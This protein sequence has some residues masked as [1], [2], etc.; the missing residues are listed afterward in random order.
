MARPLRYEAAGAVYHVMARGDG[1]KNVFE[2]DRDRVAWFS[3]M[4]RAG[5]RFGWRVHAWVLMGN[6]FHVLLETPEPNLVVGMKWLLGV[7]SQ[8]W[9]RR[10]ERRGHVFQGRYKA[11]IVNGEE[12]DGCYFRIVADYIHL[13]PVRAGWVGGATGKRLRGWRWSS[14]GAYAGGRIPAWM[15]TGKVLAAFRLSQDSAG[16]KAYAGYLEARAKDRKGTLTD[17]SS[18]CLRRGW[19]L[20]EKGFAEKVL[21]ALAASTRPKRKTGSVAGE[22]AR[23]HD[24]AEAERITVAALAALNLPAEPSALAGKGK[25]VWEKAV[26]AA[27]IRKRTGIANRWVA[28]RLGMG[29]ECN[30]TRATRLAR[31]QPRLCQRLSNLEAMLVSRD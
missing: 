30:V 12:R 8:A 27:L 17:A 24:A 26:V 31:Q 20:G 25:W 28:A 13:N 14:F 6:Y 9:N 16:G 18:E 3:L 19:C 5:E 29:H 22:A 23:A 11:V 7:Y 4:E 1:G 2:D 15:E 21:A 10:R